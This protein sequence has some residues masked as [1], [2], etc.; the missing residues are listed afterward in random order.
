MCRLIQKH[1][2]YVG[3]RLLLVPFPFLFFY[4]YAVIGLMI[5]PHLSYYMTWSTWLHLVDHSVEPGSSDIMAVR[6]LVRVTILVATKVRSDLVVRALVHVTILVATNV[7]SDLGGLNLI[8][9]EQFCDV[10]RRNFIIY[11]YSIALRGLCVWVKTVITYGIIRSC[12]GF[13]I[14]CL[15][16]L[17]SVF[18]TF[19]RVSFVSCFDWCDSC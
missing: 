18:W 12:R 14:F 6:S 13:M 19:S 5:I 10:D 4:L 7:S 11:F 16:K 8:S 17:T 15:F 1:F 3:S 2:V 9:P